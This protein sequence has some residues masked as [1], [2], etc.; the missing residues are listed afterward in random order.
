MAKPITKKTLSRRIEQILEANPDGIAVE[1]LVHQ[2][3]KKLP[4]ATDAQVREA[5]DFV[6]SQGLYCIDRGKVCLAPETAVVVIKPGQGLQVELAAERYRL[7]LAKGWEHRVLP[8]DVLEGFEDYE[9]YGSEAVFVPRK[10]VKAGMTEVVGRVALWKS[11]GKLQAGLDSRRFPGA[12]FA[13]ADPGRVSGRKGKFVS[14]K[15][16]ARPAPGRAEFLVDF[17]S[18]IQDQTRFGGEL[19]E[20]LR[21]FNLPHVF[22][23]KTLSEVAKLPSE[24]RP[25]DVR[26]RTDLTGL[27]FCT[28]DGADARDFDDAVYA[29]KAQGGYR[30]VV[31]IADVSHYVKPGSGVDEDAQMRATSVYFPRRVVPMLPEALSNGICSLNPDVRRL[32]FVC[33]MLV[34]EDGSIASYRF[35]RAVIRSRARLTYDEVYEALFAKEK[36][37]VA[38]MMRRLQAL[39]KVYEILRKARDARQAIDFESAEPAFTFDE[40][41]EIVGVADKPVTD[42][43]RLIEECMLAANVCAASFIAKSGRESLYRVHPEPSEEKIAALKESLADFGIGFGTQDSLMKALGAVLEQVRG[44]GAAKAVQ[45]LVL[46]AMMRASYSP[47]NVGHFGLQ[48]PLYT[49][50][51]SPIRRYPDL[52]VHRTIASILAG[53]AYKPEISARAQAQF[54]QEGMAPTGREDDGEGVRNKDWIALGFVTSAAERRAEEAERDI[55]KWLKCQYLEK[56]MLVENAFEAHITGVTPF[57]FFVELDDIGL[58]GLVHI[59]E[60]GDDYYVYEGSS[61]VGTDTDAN[62]RIGSAVKVRVARLSVEDRTVD[63][64]LVK[65]QEGRRRAAPVGKTRAK[66]RKGRKN[67]R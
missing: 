19:E 28:I 47:K 53:K 37:P 11:G 4:R 39:K 55:D 65:N 66:A 57:G 48:Y 58:E 7:P 26:G 50:F 44:T 64:A 62:F 14:A 38:G 29:V 15:I 6:T 2:V 3:Q 61:I 20:A 36:K 12:Q 42:A 33:D 52:L 54:E 60:I 67:G 16:L 51:T 59:S 8:G 5:L 49:H 40:R 27:E 34:A 30:L 35:Y 23:A 22:S 31:A 25:G 41:N 1:K 24:V 46:R 13:F 56:R 17:V 43:N 32:A 45:M 9:G 63:F 10:L 18:E 21:L